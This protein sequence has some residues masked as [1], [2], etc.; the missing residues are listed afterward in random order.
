M[1]FNL[2][3]FGPTLGDLSAKDQ[4]NPDGTIGT[5]ETSL[6]GSVGFRYRLNSKTSLSLGTGLKVIHPLHGAER[7]DVQTPYASY[8]STF[9]LGEFQLRS[10]P[11]LSVTTIP[12][13][14]DVGQI[15]SLTYDL[16]SIYDVLGTQWALGLDANLSLFLY[17]REYR[18]TDN[19]AS[20]GAVQLFPTVKYNFTDRTSF[21]TSTALSWLSPRYRSNETVLLNKT[22][23]QRVGVGH[24]LTRDI[25]FFPYLTVL[26]T[27]MAWDSTTFNLSTTLSLL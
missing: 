22:V 16:S 18:N 4:P 23:T 10:S 1:K 9:R 20:R 6:G 8:D 2:S 24:A 27:K 5:Y 11:G 25:Y 17:D 13:Y 12:N 19:R 3:Y 21:M 7:V 15:G 14:R 26:P